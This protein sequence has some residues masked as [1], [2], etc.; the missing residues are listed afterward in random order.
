[1]CRNMEA[2]FVIKSILSAVFTLKKL[3]KFYILLIKF[4]ISQKERG[5]V[6]F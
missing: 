1:M 2:M 4:D 6:K 5:R 3:L